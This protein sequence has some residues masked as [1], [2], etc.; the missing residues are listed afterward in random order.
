MTKPDTTVTWTEPPGPNR[1][2]RRPWE[3]IAAELR[4]H[5]GEWALVAENVSSVTT[6]A[7]TRGTFRAFEPAGAFESV[8]RRGENCEHGRTNAYARYVGGPD[9]AE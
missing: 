7:I 2:G 1:R 8:S 5:P 3:E 4:A 9:D 6:H